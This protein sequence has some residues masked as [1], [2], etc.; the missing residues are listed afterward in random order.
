MKESIEFEVIHYKLPDCITYIL[1]E[2]SKWWCERVTAGQK[3]TTAALVLFK[4]RRRDRKN[5]KMTTHLC[6]A[7]TVMIQKMIPLVE[8][9]L[10]KFVKVRQ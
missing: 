1:H 5:T 3:K 6:L 4:Q 2:Q 9:A 8:T 10:Q 7:L